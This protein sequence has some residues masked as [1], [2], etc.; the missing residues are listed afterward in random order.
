MAAT[1]P[2]RSAASTAFAP[3]WLP[4][5]GHGNGLTAP[6]WA[7][8]AD[9]DVR[10]VDPLLDLMAAARV[11]AHAA[12]A[13]RPVR[14]LLP[15]RPDRPETWRLWVGSTSYSKAEHVLVTCL[16]GLLHTLEQ[17]RYPVPHRPPHQH[18]E[19]REHHGRR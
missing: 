18:R 4:P 16:P 9:V 8:I 1:S 11:P 19:H 6:S 5:T 14:P 15:E 12:H 7:P 10:V 13:P 17:P 3:A 2:S